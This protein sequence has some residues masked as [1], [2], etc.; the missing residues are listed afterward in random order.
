MSSPLESTFT[1]SLT[2][3]PVRLCTL[4]FETF[5]VKKEAGFKV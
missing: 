3:A 4:R 1:T 5:F 2:A